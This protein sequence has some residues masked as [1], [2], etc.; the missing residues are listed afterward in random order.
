MQVGLLFG[1]SL[2]PKLVGLERA[3]HWNPVLSPD[4]SLKTADIHITLWM[5]EQRVLPS[6]YQPCIMA[7][8]RL[9]K[10]R[11]FPNS[12]DQLSCLGFES[13]NFL[14]KFAARDLVSRSGQYPRCLRQLQ[15]RYRP[16]FAK[17][18]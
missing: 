2:F 18:K 16:R 8:L 7:S 13:A 15:L 1:L 9:H 12:F 11:N 10:G 4:S 3:M 6:S 14:E 5:R 17:Q